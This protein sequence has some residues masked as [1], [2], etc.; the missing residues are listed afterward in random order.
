MLLSATM[1]LFLVA[2]GN[3]QE[4]KSTEA[5]ADTTATATTATTETVN[6]TITTPQNMMVATHKV[7]DFTKWKAS[8]DEHD[9]MR[10]ANGVHSYVIGRGAQDSNTVLVAVKVDDLGKAKTFAKDPSLKK[11]MAKGGVVGAPTI[12]FITME[13]QDT[14]TVGTDLR[15]RTTFTV[16]DWDAWKKSFDSTR[17]FLAEN[18]LI[19]R[20]Y[21]HDADDNHKVTLVTAIADTAKAR[22]YWNSDVLKQRRAASG[23]IGEPQRFIYHMVQRY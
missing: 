21:G 16:K 15:S 19:L 12:R 6:T 17:Q 23:V 13:F 7:K 18:G 14:G 2:C 5:T 1:T 3:N 4:Q 20:A 11:A 22:S 10:L 9:S 8:Y